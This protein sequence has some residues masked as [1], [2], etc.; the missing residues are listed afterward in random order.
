[1]SPTA[2]QHLNIK[3][4]DPAKVLTAIF[5]SVSNFLISEKLLLVFMLASV[6]QELSLI[7]FYAN[8]ALTIF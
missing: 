1:M 3:F 7:F 8:L 2:P 5:F 6:L 4:A